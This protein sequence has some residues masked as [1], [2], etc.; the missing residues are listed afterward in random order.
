M[1]EAV[2]STSVKAGTKTYFFDVKRAKAGKQSL[3]I[4]ITEAR[5]QDDKRIRTTITV[6]PDQ[7]PAFMQAIE[8]S[9]AH[10]VDK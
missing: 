5:T 8:T 7:L 3:Y 2:F 1:I 4:Q 6:F 10:M 9:V